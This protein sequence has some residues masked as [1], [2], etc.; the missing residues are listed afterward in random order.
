MKSVLTCDRNRTCIISSVRISVVVA[1]ASDDFMCKSRSLTSLRGTLL[2]HPKANISCDLL[3]TGVPLGI[4][5]AFEPLGGILSANLPVCYAL[6]VKI[7][8][9]VRSS[10][11]GSAASSGSQSKSGG[12]VSAMSGSG[13]RGGGKMPGPEETWIQLEQ[14]V[15]WSTDSK[16]SATVTYP[17]Y[18]PYT[19]VY[20]P[21]R[22]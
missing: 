20:S 8:R 1:Q 15:T 14:Q 4:M 7:T 5:S 19:E 18:P 11:Y 22:P 16:P 9:K 12:R 3:G 2:H 21:R 6:F 10:F 17:P 13:R